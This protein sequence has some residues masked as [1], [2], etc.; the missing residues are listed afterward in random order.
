V[1]PSSVV[2]IVE[3]VVVVLS[4]LLEF[5]Q[6]FDFDASVVVVG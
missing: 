6:G 4:A 5:L 3:G 2:F 1:T